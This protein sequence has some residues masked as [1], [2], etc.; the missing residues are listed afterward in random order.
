MLFVKC[1]V[2]KVSS[3]AIILV[4]LS[5]IHSICGFSNSLYF[6]NN[7]IDKLNMVGFELLPEF[8]I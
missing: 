5:K 6:A 4:L 8:I 3:H 2:E 1:N 7:E